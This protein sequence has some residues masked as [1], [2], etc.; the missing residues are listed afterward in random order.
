MHIAEQAVYA[1]T[2]TPLDEPVSIVP[3]MSQPNSRFELI[4]AQGESL[5]SDLGD[6][7]G[8]LLQAAYS[9][10]GTGRPLLAPLWAEEGM[11]RAYAMLRLFDRRAKRHRGRARNGFTAKV[12]CALAHSLASAYRSL[13]TAEEEEVV[14]CATLLREVALNLGA[15]FGGGS[16]IVVRTVIE[17]L[18]LPAYKRRA[19]VLSA[20]ELM[21]NALTHAFS[22]AARDGRIEVS[23]RQV[24]EKRACLRVA[25]NGSGLGARRPDTA[26]SIA[27]GLA[28]LIEADL[29][30]GRTAGWTTIAE[31]V[32]PIACAASSRTARI[33][34]MA[35]HSA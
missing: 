2:G 8:L 11:H 10:E 35:H 3:Q 16:G 21:I 19:L 34:D 9:A 33:I 14:Q 29:T 5:P 20:S 23:L 30:Y 28:D 1:W 4:A 31:I 22:A 17:R 6:L 24:D 26:T 7:L 18:H 13:A 32:F 12:E 15:L 27:G 25:D